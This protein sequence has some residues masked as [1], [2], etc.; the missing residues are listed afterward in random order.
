MMRGV[1]WAS[2]KNI[3]RFECSNSQHIKK[4]F[5]SLAI[6]KLLLFSASHIACFCIQFGVIYLMYS[7][8][9]IT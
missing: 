6:L 9:E 4:G 7:A 1:T 2:N 5:T 8:I 3:L